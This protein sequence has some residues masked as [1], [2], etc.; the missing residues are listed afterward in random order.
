MGSLKLINCTIDFIMPH[1]QPDFNS[2]ETAIRKRWVWAHACKTTLLNSFILLIS[3]LFGLL[4][5]FEIAGKFFAYAFGGLIWFWV[6]YHC[7]YKYRGTKWLTF[8]LVTSPILFLIDLAYNVKEAQD[9]LGVEFTL[10]VVLNVASTVVFG[11]WY[12]MS[13]KMRRLNK[14]ETVEELPQAG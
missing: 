5:L 7:A 8:W 6:G 3:W 9:M 10:Y 14:K 12:S 11:W 13:L 1:K 2:L 4:G